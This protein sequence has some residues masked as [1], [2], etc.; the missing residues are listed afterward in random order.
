MKAFFR[1]FGI[2][3]LLLATLVLCAWS[4][5]CTSG[6]PAAR[7]GVSSASLVTLMRLEPAQVEPDLE[8]Y[9][10]EHDRYVPTCTAFAVKRLGRVQLATA[11]HCVRDVLSVRY[12]PPSGWGLGIAT[13]QDISEARDVAFL[14]VEQG[15]LRPLEMAAQPG[16]GERV[17][18]FSAVYDQ[19]S[20]G[21]VLAQYEEGWYETSQTIVYGWSGSP[22]VDDAGRAV[23]VVSKC[24]D[25]IQGMPCK[26]GHALVTSL[27]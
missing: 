27:E 12:V 14:D 3:V 4:T 10:S 13:V 9:G 7:A 11:A 25:T 24:P 18:A 15:E 5:A 8:G 17:R 2:V 20:L 6:R 21:R 19:T 16:T 22:V 1:D 23:G 26:P